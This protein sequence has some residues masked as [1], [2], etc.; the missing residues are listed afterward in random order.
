MWRICAIAG[1]P[2]EKGKP[3]RPVRQGSKSEVDIMAIIS[4]TQTAAEHVQRI[5]GQ[6]LICGRR[7]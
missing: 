7:A 6:R 1:Q 2:A 4:L 3:A 5:A